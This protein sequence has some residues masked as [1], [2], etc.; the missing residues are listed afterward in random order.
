MTRH[1]LHREATPWQEVTLIA[2]AR[3]P[4]RWRVKCGAGPGE[5]QFLRVRHDIGVSIHASGSPGQERLWV[6][7]R[8]HKSVALSGRGAMVKKAGSQ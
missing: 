3:E 2:K 1:V 6:Q 5:R 7:L 4:R 8:P